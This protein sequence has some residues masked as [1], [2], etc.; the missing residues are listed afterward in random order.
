MSTIQLSRSLWL[1]N[2][3]R[4]YGRLTRAQ[5]NAH[6]RASNY[7]NDRDI[8]R[9]TF[10]NFRDEVDALFHI[11]IAFD[12]RT[13]EYYIAEDNEHVR[14]RNSWMLHT[15]A[16]NEMLVNSKGV[17]QLIFLEDV[18]SA[19]S[20]LELVIEGLKERHPMRFDYAPYTRSTPSHGVIVEPYFLKLFKQRWYVTGRAVRDGD[21]IKTYALD[22]MIGP[23]LMAESYE[24][25]AHFDAETY[26]RDSF[27]VVFTH[28]EVKT[29]KLRVDARQAKYFRAV[30][31]HPSQKEMIHDTF[32]EFRYRMKIS[33]DFVEEILSHGSRV[34]VISPPELKAMVVSELEAALDA[35]K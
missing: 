31:L 33:P 5:I 32:S 29:I 11:K 28:G 18:P 13:N 24:I 17:E 1:V 3:L 23:E 19:R 34:T 35:Y 12:A 26:F 25:P 21:V 14:N 10:Y 6:W 22:R 2:L 8:P 7:S 15:Q 30:P 4:R 16:M 9:R 27:G 20:H